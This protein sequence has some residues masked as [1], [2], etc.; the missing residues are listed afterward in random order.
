M[1]DLNEDNG[2]E[3]CLSHSHGEAGF[4]YSGRLEICGCLKSAQRSVQAANTS[5][6]GEKRREGIGWG[7]IKS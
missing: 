5:P 1:A 6:V 3:P 2:I 7:G 4:I